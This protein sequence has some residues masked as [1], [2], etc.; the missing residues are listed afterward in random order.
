MILGFSEVLPKGP[1][2]SYLSLKSCGKCF[3]GCQRVSATLGKNCNTAA[4]N[5]KYLSEG[6]HF[7][8]VHS[9]HV[10]QDISYQDTSYQRILDNLPKNFCPV[11]IQERATISQ[12]L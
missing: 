5:Y 12:Y 10:P 9:G 11:G 1:L 2:A 3:K 6:R 4:E 8:P 7:F